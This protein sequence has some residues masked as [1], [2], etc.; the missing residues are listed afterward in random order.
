MKYKYKIENLDCAN[1]AKE[2]ENHLNKDPN[3]KNV[4]CN[5]SKSTLT[6]ETTLTKNIKKYVSKKSKEVEPDITILE[7]NE[8]IDAK[9]NTKKDIIILIVG[10]F[11]I[12]L[13]HLFN[14]NKIIKEILCISALIVL[15]SKTTIKAIK[16][17]IK[18]HTINENMLISISCIGAFLIGKEM[19]GLMVIFLYQIGKIL[20]S[21]ALNNSRKSISNLMDIKPDYACVL[22]NN[23]QVI[24]NPE[25]VK[26]GEI[27]IV[28]KG[29]KIPLDGIIIKGNSKLDNSSLTGESKLVSVKEQDEVLSGTI[30]IGN[31]LEIKVTK[32]YENST[33]AQIL[34]LVENASDKKAKTENF[35][36]HAAKI[37]TPV[38][39][40]LSII[41]FITY[42]IFF[43]YTIKEAL[44]ISLTYLVISCPCAIAISVPLS[45]FSGIG[46]S[47]KNGILIKGSDYLD[48]LRK[49]KTIIFDKTGT[50]TTGNFEDLNLIILDN[51]YSKND[52]I[53]YYDKGESLS[54]HPIGKSIVK[55]F[56]KKTN[57]KD[58]KNFKE[59]SGKGISYEIDSTKVKIGS[60]EFVKSKQ[61]EK[62][63][64]LKVDSKIIAKIELK[65]KIKPNSKKVISELKKINIKTMMF[66]GDKKEIAEEI[67]EKVNIDEVK[68]ELLPNQKYNELIKEMAKDNNLVGFVG[69]GINDAPSIVASNIGFSM[70][71]IGSSSAIEASDIVIIDDDLDKIRKA[72]DISKYTAKII[73]ENLIFSISTKIIILILTSMNQAT[74]AAAVFADT[75]VTVLTILN[76]TRILKHKIK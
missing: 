52:I 43:D 27:I 14:Q 42:P 59:I 7:L 30:N 44:N 58:V 64:F 41:V 62:G 51:E 75:G 2:L 12:L 45:Y 17:L 10:L 53:N 6:I 73:K 11:L 3:L 37:Y 25:E 13:S 68:Y 21:L 26:I 74:M 49:L 71:N 22:R 57:T 54:N 18:S 66:T 55:Y 47:S 61:L 48:N 50:I 56:A 33:V 29:E 15:L 35:V 31:I 23:E 20:E 76:T 1:C 70:G 24:V 4:S 8:N 65:D 40:I 16:M 60:A 9:N 67:A 5:F 36:S 39:L 34:E 72:I 28:K 63:I 32:D 38:V 19:E 46:V 69:D